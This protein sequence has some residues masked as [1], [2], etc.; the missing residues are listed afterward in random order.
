MRLL[1]VIVGN[2]QDPQEMLDK[3]F[4]REYI[5]KTFGG[6]E[7][8]VTTDLVAEKI[9]IHFKE[10]E[11]ASEAP[12]ESISE[13]EPPATDPAPEAEATKEEPKKGE[14]EAK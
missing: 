13:A 9:L 6:L 2:R 4:G 1:I 5:P 3:E 7:G 12:T 10:E 8:D 11:A 14:A